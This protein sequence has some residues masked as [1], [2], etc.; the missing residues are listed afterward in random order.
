MTGVQTCALPIWQI[1][2]REYGL[3]TQPLLQHAISDHSEPDAK[4]RVAVTASI[5]EAGRAV[6]VR[7]VGSGPIDAFVAALQAS[8][9]HLLQVVGYHEHALGAGADARAISYVEMRIDGECTLFGVGQHADIVAASFAAIL[10]AL[11]RAKIGWQAGNRAAPAAY[12][13]TTSAMA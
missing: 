9:G 7:G 6:P 1:F 13:S 10:S 11:S 8:S 2:E 3:T 5:G 4:R 12:P